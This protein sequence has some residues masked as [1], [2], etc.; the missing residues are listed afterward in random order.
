MIFSMKSN[1]IIPTT[2]ILLDNQATTDVFGNADLLEDIHEVTTPLQIRSADNHTTRDL[3]GT[4]YS[5]VSPTCQCQYSQ[6]G[7]IKTSLSHHI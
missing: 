5:V 1:H 4:W 7:Q 2:W 6:Y 3:T